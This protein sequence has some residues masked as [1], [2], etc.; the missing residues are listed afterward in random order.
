MKAKL[1]SFLIG[2][3][4]LAQ[5]A[6]AQTAIY[7]MH[8]KMKNGSTNTYKADDVQEVYFTASQPYDPSHPVTA[9]VESIHAPKEGGTYI[10]HINS[11]IPLSTSSGNPD[12]L[13]VDDYFDHFL[14][15]APVSLTSTYN[16]GTLTITV[17]P[18]TCY[19]VDNREVRLFDLEGT[20]AFS[21]TVSQDGDPNATL[22]GENGNNYIS[23]LAMSM[24]DS[25]AKYR[26]ADVNYTGLISLDGFMAPLESY[27]YRVR[28]IWFTIYQGISRNMQLMENCERPGMAIFKPMCA[29]LNA[30]SYYELVTFFGGVPYYTNVNDAMEY[31]PRTE[32]NVIFSNLIEQLKEAM[33]NMEE[34]VTGYVNSSEKMYKMSK[35]I[36][37]VLLAEIYMYQGRYMEA[38][39]LL[40]DI[41][42]SHRYSLVSAVDNLDPQ[43]SEII[44]SQA[45][46]TPTRAKANDMTVVFFND[47]LCIMQTY[48]D[49]LLS[50][51]ECENK[52]NNDSKAKEYLNQVA[53]AK[54]IETTSTETLAAISEIRH[55]IQID[56]G[57]YF[58]FLKRTGQAQTTLGLE[59]YQLLF[60]I[61]QDE[62]SRNPM[63]T[64]DPGYGETTR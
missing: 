58:A 64:Q 26:R 59:E 5:V 45:V 62:I 1:F 32:P 41:V 24:H 34:K 17:N 29:V 42:N 60:P 18:T 19:I 14:N 57:G 54:G 43:C 15:Q 23:S 10:V 39:P 30:M 40:E 47:D 16:E 9:D 3:A 6:T 56:F 44:W 61:P 33:G 13:V 27:D 63:I 21:L 35:D 22:I 51:A 25:H 8:V 48:G 52:L 31:L 55:R 36:A 4:A 11:E 49:V 37:R 50:L 46:N 7:R 12:A 20:E 38:K 2:F 53:S 28:E